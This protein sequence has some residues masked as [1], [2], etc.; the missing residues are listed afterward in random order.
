[1]NSV[2]ALKKAREYAKNLSYGEIKP[3]QNYNN[4]ENIPITNVRGSLVSPLLLSDFSSG[5]YR[6]TGN[7]YICNEKDT[8]YID[9]SGSN[10]FFISKETNTILKITSSSISFFNLS[11]NSYTETS[12]PTLKEVIKLIDDIKKIIPTN[13]SELENDNGFITDDELKEYIDENFTKINTRE[14]ETLFT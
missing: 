10:L 12:V 9:A 5:I 6:I 7:Y 4:L 8:C 14:I 1:M 13:L 3:D 2:I 11:D